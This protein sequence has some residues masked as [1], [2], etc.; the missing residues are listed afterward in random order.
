LI[1]ASQHSSAA[2]QE[3]ERD[4][5]LPLR[6]ELAADEAEALRRRVTAERNRAA[7]ERM[8]RMMSPGRTRG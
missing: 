4:L 2:L 1:E 7:S 3:L 5:D 8:M 6:W